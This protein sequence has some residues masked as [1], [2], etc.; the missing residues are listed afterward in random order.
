MKFC[1]MDIIQSLFIF[2]TQTNNDQ[3]TLLLGILRSRSMDNFKRFLEVLRESLYGWLADGIMDTPMHQSKLLDDM[4]QYKTFK[5][6]LSKNS[7]S[8]DVD[9]NFSRSL[10]KIDTSPQIVQRRLPGI[11]GYSYDYQPNGYDVNMTSF[12]RNI[13]GLH[14]DFKSQRVETEHALSMLRQEE[15]AIKDLWYQNSREQEHLYRNHRLLSDIDRRLRQI[16]SDAG[17]LMRPSPNVEHTR[18]RLYR[19]QRVPWEG[20]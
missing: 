7:E 15:R 6:Y 13:F 2:Q 17:Q 10:V 16:Q 4:L 19:L 12:P 3:I 9:D 20:R 14:S 5:E 18:Q 11:S 1:L 8:Y